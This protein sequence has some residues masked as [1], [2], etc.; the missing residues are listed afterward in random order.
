MVMTGFL[1]NND[2]YLEAQIQNTAQVPMV[3]EKVTLEPSDFYISSEIS[4]PETGYF[5]EQFSK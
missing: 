1:Q 3:L 5:S 4:L 2:V